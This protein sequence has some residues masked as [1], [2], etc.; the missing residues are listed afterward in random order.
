MKPAPQRH[1]VVPVNVMSPTVVTSVHSD[2]CVQ[3]V[4]GDVSLRERRS[5]TDLNL[6]SLISFLISYLFMATAQLFSRANK[7][8]QS[9]HADVAQL[10][11]GKD[12]SV[13]L[14]GSYFNHIDL[15][16]RH[17]LFNRQC[18]CGLGK[19]GSHDQ[20]LSGTCLP[21]NGKRKTRRRQTVRFLK[22][23]H[24]N[25]ATRRLSILKEEYTSLRRSFDTFKKKE[26]DKVGWRSSESLIHDE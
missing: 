12:V 23:A 20:G 11:S 14:Q 6:L 10:E 4:V 5:E 25:I 15:Q 18:L 13:G 9:L 3:P 8:V 7:L 22:W 21:R 19:S 17:Q 2:P 16:I 1:V 26:Q 24:V